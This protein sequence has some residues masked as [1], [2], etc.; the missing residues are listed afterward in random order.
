MM[1]AT[2]TVIA[3]AI[4]GFVGFTLGGLRSSRP[5]PEPTVVREVVERPIDNLAIRAA[6]RDELHA[7]R[8]EPPQ[9]QQT[10][11]EPQAVAVEPSRE[12]IAARRDADALIAA[13]IGAGHWREEDRERFAVV[14]QHLTNIERDEVL[15]PLVVAI[16]TQRLALD[17][18]GPIL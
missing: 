2:G 1:R 14:A 8:V 9:P 13:A 12:Q 10:V 18:T 6:I 11:A 16:N 7:P 3:V 17:Y 4:A 5:A 15:R